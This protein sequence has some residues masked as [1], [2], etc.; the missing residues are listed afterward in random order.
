M[1]EEKLFKNGKIFT[2]NKQLPYATAFI[3]K[4]GKITWIGNEKDIPYPVENVS[5]LD[6]KR[7][8]PGIIDPH[9][10]PLFLAD[11]QASISCIAPE[12]NSINELIEKIQEERKAKS[13][14]EWIEGWGYDE[15]KL[16]EGRAPNRYD[17]DKGAEDVPVVITRTCGHII[18]VNSKALELAGIDENTKDIPGG[19]IDRDENGIP[20]GILRENARLLVLKL[21]NL[22]TQSEN[23][24]KLK[25]LGDDLAR[26]GITSISELMAE[27]SPVDYLKMYRKA[28]DNGM[29][30]RVAIFY[31]WEEFQ[32]MT[33]TP[34]MFDNE[35]R[36]FISGIKLFADGS[37]SG[38]TA[39]VDKPYLIGAEEYGISTTSIEELQAA[40][41]VAK[42]NGIQLAVH[43]MGERAIHQV[44]DA[45]GAYK[46]WMDTAP[47]IRIEHAT[48]PTE[49]TM[50]IAVK[51]E[52]AFLPQP[53]FLYAE[54]ETYLNN[55]GWEKTKHS[56]P[57]K[58]M[59]EKGVR[60]ALSSDAPATSWSDPVNPFIGIQSAVTRRAYNDE[61]TGQD[62]R[63]SVETAIEL[64]TREAQV[65]S[66][67]PNIGQL[68]VG[69]EADFVILDKDILEVDSDE[70]SDITV[71]ATYIA[72]EKVYEKNNTKENI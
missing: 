43:A 68:T 28:I 44:I 2:S 54:I 12:T 3:V 11:A 66:N 7:V 5:D 23:A 52:I 1:H 25:R 17:L 72:G 58:T 46:N 38:L 51:S 67:F 13:E 71:Q 14:N 62:E 37:I 65:V 42:A 59:L 40:Y 45:V 50:D 10:H 21:K 57:I 29:K 34:D 36:A 4:N 26:Y 56:Y 47:G 19:E 61:D 49:R 27:A 64:Y 33:V 30:Q 6:G 69:Y 15:G 18:S 32:K 48:F 20:T 39:W 8:I 35:E 41:K 53:I 55:V 63:I 9:L 24:K 70:I 16:T 31:S 60:V 22:A